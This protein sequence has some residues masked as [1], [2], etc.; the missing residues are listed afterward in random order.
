[1]RDISTLITGTPPN[2]RGKTWAPAWP[3]ATKLSRMP[4][5]FALCTER[6][7]FRKSQKGTY[8]FCSAAGQRHVAHLRGST[9]ERNQEN[10]CAPLFFRGKIWITPTQARAAGKRKLFLGVGRSGGVFRRW[11]DED[12]HIG[13][14]FLRLQFFDWRNRAA[15]RLIRQCN[16]R[17]RVTR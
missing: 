11:T 5:H 6:V 8:V 9:V 3:C 15:T 16:D 17:F 12:G 7:P 2:G 1:M 13:H 4:D 10:R 14:P